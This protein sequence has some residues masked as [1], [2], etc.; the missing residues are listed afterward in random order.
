M[1]RAD[2]R[3]AIL[4]GG[5]SLV[6]AQTAVTTPCVTPTISTCTTLRTVYTQQTLTATNVLSANFLTVTSI[7]R[8]AGTLSPNPSV[9]TIAQPFLLL[10]GTV[11]VLYNPA[12][13]TNTVLG[14]GSA[15]ITSTISQ[16]A[17]PTPG[18]VDVFIPS[19]VTVTTTSG[20][21]NTITT[22]RTPAGTVQGTV[23]VVVPS[24][25]VVYCN[26]NGKFKASF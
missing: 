3:A 13:V 24:S 25:T 7:Y 15:T 1:R 11:E 22:V 18:L 16:Q 8:G 4:L 2:L 6:A 17:G 12:T 20:F 19:Y 23:E 10:P 26:L 5:G 14:S 21:I 9:T